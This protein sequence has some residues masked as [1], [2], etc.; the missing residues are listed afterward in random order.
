MPMEG[1]PTDPTQT[2]EKRIRRG[3]VRYIPVNG[4]VVVCSGPTCYPTHLMSP[5]KQASKELVEERGEEGEERGK[6]GEERGEE[7][8]ERTSPD[9]S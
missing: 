7:G 3:G 2:E 6:E 4:C 5:Q 8:E 9:S 1:K